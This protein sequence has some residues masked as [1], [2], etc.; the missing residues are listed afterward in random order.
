MFGYA[1]CRL[2]FH[3]Y[4]PP[5][6]AQRFSHISNAI[7][8][9][10]QVVALTLDLASLKSVRNFVEEFAEQGLPPLRVL[11]CNAGIQVVSGTTFTEDGFETTFGV[12]H[13][14]HFLLVNL[15][16]KNLVA[17]ARIIVVSSD[18]HDPAQK[19]GMPEPYYDHAVSLALSERSVDTPQTVEDSTIGRRRY[20]TSKLCNIYFTYELS[21]RLEKQGLSTNQKPITANAFN[22][23]LMPG[24]G[25]ARDYNPR[26]RFVWSYILP[27]IRPIMRSLMPMNSVSDSG[28][29]LA[30]L[31]L[32]PSLERISGKY[33]SGLKEEPSSKESYDT[34]KAF[35][36]WETSASLAKLTP[37]ETPLQ[38]SE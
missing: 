9:G 15:F 16:I 37:E 13:L 35:E 25:L 18:T 31:V 6:R 27:V 33:Y 7:T 32:D 38:I 8:L 2:F 10:S 24:T 20:T 11:I 34:K 21:R 29:A 26:M 5:S 30:R 19:T 28:Q 14:G 22:P 12:N 4:A 17:P 1:F 3:R 23:G 36:L